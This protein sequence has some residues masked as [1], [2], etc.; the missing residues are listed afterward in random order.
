MFPCKKLFSARGRPLKERE[1][2]LC[3][4]LRVPVPS[5]ANTH[6]PRNLLLAVAAVAAVDVAANTAGPVG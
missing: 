3:S 2:A 5:Q 4:G 1:A 6:L